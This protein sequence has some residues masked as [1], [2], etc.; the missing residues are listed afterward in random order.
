M[1]KP[2]FEIRYIILKSKILT[3]NILNLLKKPFT[4]GLILF[5]IVTANIWATA[6]TYTSEGWDANGEPTS[7]S[8]ADTITIEADC[9]LSALTN[10][11]GATI[12]IQSGA[13]LT[14]TGDIEFNAN[15]VN[16]GS[17][18]I[19]NSTSVFFA[20]Y[21]GSGSLTN[22][23]NITFP[24]NLILEGSVTN[25]SGASITSNSIRLG[26]TTNTSASITNEGTISTHDSFNNY[27]SVDNSGTF[28]VTNSITNHGII[29]NTGTMSASTSITKVQVLQIQVP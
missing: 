28:S 7:I 29:N 15:V 23:G 11:S 13:S 22:N 10:Q 26:S 25:Q 20:S 19:A 12:T 6:Y 1:V 8:S 27:G 16:K 2:I 3:S 24:T 21:S 18:I 5:T 4:L 17:L 14:V 9:S